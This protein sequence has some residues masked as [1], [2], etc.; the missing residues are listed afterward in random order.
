[1]K[2]DKIFMMESNWK[3]M[4][5]AQFFKKK[6]NPTN[7]N[8]IQTMLPCDA[9]ELILLFTF[10]CKLFKIKLNQYKLDD[11]TNICIQI[12]ANC[13]LGEHSI[14]KNIYSGIWKISLQ[15]AWAQRFEKKLTTIN[16]FENLRQS[17]FGPFLLLFFPM[18]RMF[19]IKKTS[20]LFN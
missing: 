16:R 9:F 15:N 14:S 12:A 20:P 11:W 3:N 1:M 18:N 8:S 19:F 6:I 4:F 13:S 2:P 10:P 17:N 7:N 5:K